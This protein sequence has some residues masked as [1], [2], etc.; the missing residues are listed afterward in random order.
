M[1]MLRRWIGDK[2]FAAGLRLYF[3][4]HQ[5]RN[6]VGRD[7][8]QAL[9]EASGKDV[10]AFM[11]AW[12]EQPGYPV[13]TARVDNDQLILSQKQFFIGEASDQKRL[14]PIPLNA[15]W[16]GLP[17]VL[18]EESIVISGFSQLAAQNKGT[19]RFN[20]ENTAH[21]I[22]DYQGQLF[23]SL[24][25]DLKHLDNTS[26]LQV[27]QER[28]LLA[29]SGLIS[30]AELVDLIA[31]LDDK[32]SYMV[33]AAVQQVIRGLEQFI[34]EGTSA[35]QSFNR[36]ISSIFQEDFRQ[37]GFEKRANESDEDEMVRQIAL[38]HL[39]VGGNRDVIKQAKTIFEAYANRIEAIP[40]AI[41]RSVL[42]SQIKYFEIADLV[43]AYF[44][45]YV[46]TKD[47]NLRADLSAA[48][49]TTANPST[50]KRIQYSLKDKDI[51][52][53]QDL[54][55]WYSFLL[56][57]ASAQESIWRWARENWKW[58]KASLGGDMSFDKFI[59]YPANHFKTA[60]RL[61][62]YKAF[63]EP[64][65]DDM[66]ISRNI[67]MGINEISAR[68]ALIDSEKEAIANALSQY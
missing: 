35:E 14:W 2:D 32:K 10:A 13:L 28:R 41:R 57:Q 9:S 53:P 52:K 22:T 56:D 44:D 31:Q 18:T 63:F 62:E 21:Y 39:L 25:D 3:E 6:T 48:L 46:A 24:V 40:A 19:L 50:L 36:L 61:A 12:L 1:H 55:A 26:A 4:K 15:N 66:A 5:Y 65:L 47:N 67:S 23:H 59:I 60:E 27:I 17:D 68:V 54:A 11:D 29:D 49:A 34:D 20:T 37:L 51:I 8:W 58:I 33:A 16:K 7:L 45:A 42:V 43:D 64:Q 30:Y 38:H